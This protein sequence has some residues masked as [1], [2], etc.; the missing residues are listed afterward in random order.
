MCLFMSVLLAEFTA[1]KAQNIKLKEKKNTQKTPG[2]SWNIIP[3]VTV[4]TIVLIDFYN[5]I[6]YCNIQ[7]LTST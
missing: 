1:V 5:Y 4:C 3:Q 6:L 2:I 7:L